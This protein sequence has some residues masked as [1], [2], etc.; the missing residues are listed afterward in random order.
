MPPAV[1]RRED[2]E[3]HH[4][5]GEGEHRGGGVA[6]VALLLV[7]ELVRREADRA[8]AAEPRPPGRRLGDGFVGASGELEVDVV[9]RSA[10]STVSPVE[11][12]A[13]FERPTHEVVSTRTSSLGASAQT[14][15]S[16]SWCVD[17]MSPVDAAGGSP[18][19][20]RTA[21]SA[22]PPIV[23]GVPAATISPCGD[24]GHAVGE[25]L[26]LVHVVRG[27]ENVVPRR[28][29][30]SHESQACRRAAGS[31]PVVGSS[32]N[33]SSGRADRCQGRRRDGAAGR[34]R[35]TSPAPRPSRRAR[36]ARGHRRPRRG[37][38][39]VAGVAA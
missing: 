34:R 20:M 3:E 17:G 21:A 25:V 16:L 26:R 30:C 24:D 10:R 11:V 18:N 39:V 27:E 2:H 31:K 23:S 29:R 8:H 6:P 28:R 1:Q 33:S 37:C 7:S 12:D 19:R 36:P 32:R 38:R 14:R 9:E 35:A 5:E 4:R 15:P 13:V 22:R